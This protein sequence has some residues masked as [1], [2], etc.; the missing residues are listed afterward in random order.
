MRNSAV[1]T[2]WLH[3]FTDG[4][5]STPQPIGFITVEAKGPLNRRLCRII[6]NLG[7]DA[8]CD[9]CREHPRFYNFTK[10]AEVLPFVHA[11]EMEREVLSGQYA[12]GLYHLL[13]VSCYAVGVIFGAV[14]LFLR[15]MN[16]Q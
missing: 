8:L 3:P 11:V 10:V 12:A 7:E 13:P 1:P 2:L 9:I 6:L 14:F 4:I 15:Q 5:A 16:K